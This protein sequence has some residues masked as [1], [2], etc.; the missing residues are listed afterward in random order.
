MQTENVGY[1]PVRLASGGFTPPV[2][3]RPRAGRSSR[4][5]STGG[6]LI[7]HHPPWDICEQKMEGRAR[8]GGPGRDQVCGMVAEVAEVGAPPLS[9]QVVSHHADEGAGEGGVFAAPAFVG[10][11]RGVERRGRA[12]ARRRRRGPEELLGRRRRPGR[13]GGAGRRGAG[14]G[15]AGKVRRSSGQSPRQETRVRTRP[16][17]SCVTSAEWN[18]WRL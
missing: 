5:P 16:A 15:A 8:P 3:A 9:G 14:I 1:R 13:R 18:L 6:F 11:D 7:A 17:A 10:D 2:P 4:K 12:A